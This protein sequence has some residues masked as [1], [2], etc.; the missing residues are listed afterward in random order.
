[1]NFSRLLTPLIGQRVYKKNIKICNPHLQL[2]TKRPGWDNASR[3][4]PFGKRP[5]SLDSLGACGALDAGSNPAPGPQ[6]ASDSWNRLVWWA[7][8]TDWKFAPALQAGGRGF[9]SHPVHSVTVFQVYGH[10]CIFLNNSSRQKQ[11]EK[12]ITAKKRKC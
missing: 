3:K 12:F 10:F 4:H 7:G 8:S 11:N 1:M 5:M 2:K 9:K 6:S